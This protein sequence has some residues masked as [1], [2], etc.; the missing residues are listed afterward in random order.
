MPMSANFQWMWHE[1]L[2]DIRQLYL[3]FMYQTQQNIWKQIQAHY[4][5]ITDK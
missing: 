3:Y 2:T 1:K 5:Y 4:L